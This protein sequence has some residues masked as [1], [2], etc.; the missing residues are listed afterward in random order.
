MYQVAKALLNDPHEHTTLSLIYANMTVDD[1]L[2]RDELDELTLTH[3][4]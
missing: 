3:S 1:I 2:L 4:R